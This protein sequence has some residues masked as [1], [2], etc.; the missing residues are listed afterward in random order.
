MRMDYE[1][2]STPINWLSAGLWIVLAL[3]FVGLFILTNYRVVP[4][5]QP[6]VSTEVGTHYATVENSD[7]TKAAVIAP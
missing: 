4:R 7:A 5:A 6:A 2:G 1:T 3:G